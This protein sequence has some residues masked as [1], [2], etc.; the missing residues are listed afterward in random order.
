MSV[1]A[2]EP[3]PAEAR[4]VLSSSF[5]DNVAFERKS[6]C[7]YKCAIPGYSFGSE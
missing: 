6:T 3:L 1:K 2:F 7:S 5:S 4:K